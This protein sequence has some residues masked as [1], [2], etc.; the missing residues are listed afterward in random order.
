MGVASEREPTTAPGSIFAEL[1][2]RG[3]EAARAK[4]DTG[5]CAF[6]RAASV[7]KRPRVA[8]NQLGFPGGCT[9]GTGGH[10]RVD[11]SGGGRLTVVAGTRRGLVHG[12]RALVREVDLYPPVKSFFER[13][14]YD[15]K[16]EIGGCDLVAVR[17]GEPHVIVELKLTFTLGLVL[18]GVD[19]LAVADSVYLAVPARA[20]RRH[21]IRPLCRRLGLGLISVHEPRL[22][23]EVV[24]DPGPYRPPHDRKRSTRLLGEHARRRGDPTAGGATRVPIMTAY[25]QEALR[26]AA[27]LAHG[28]ASV[29][30]LRASA[31][32]PNAGRILMRDAYGWFERVRRGVY[33]L[34]DDGRT[35]LLHFGADG[36]QPQV[37]LDSDEAMAARGVAR[38]G[39]VP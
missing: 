18:Q 28:P 35:A 38:A 25:R 24:V 19:R 37:P 13:H 7:W 3:C 6:V 1:R 11:R 30:A 4:A 5:R 21:G 39:V 32:A 2:D 9:R 27:V 36:I 33:C 34:R 29:G 12:S 10:R 14:G 22:D 17:D 15:V 8:S 16:G 26:V 23:V 20:A 31:D